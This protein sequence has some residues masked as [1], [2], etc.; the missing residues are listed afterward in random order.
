MEA[1]ELNSEKRLALIH[2]VIAP[3]GKTLRE[4][5]ILLTDRRSI[6]IRL[7][8]SRSDFVLRGETRYG[9]ALVTD[10]IPKT[11]ADYEQIRLESLTGDPANLSITYEAVVSLVMKKEVPSFRARDFLIWLTMRRQGEVFQVY[12]FEMTYQKSPDQRTRF[13]FYMVPLGAYFKLRRQTQSRVTILREYAL[14]GLQ[15]FQGLLPAGVVSSQ[16]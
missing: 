11:L 12:N 3:D 7:E 5:A 16:E 4:Y 1:V 14:D 15:T 10:V 9:T 8:K 6:F 2:R 13:R